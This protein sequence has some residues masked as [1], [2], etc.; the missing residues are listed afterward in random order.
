MDLR[1]FTVYDI[2]KR[3]ARVFNMRVAIQ[4]EERRITFG[5]LYDQTHA[6]IGALASREIQ[7]GDRIAVLTR[8]R[9]EFFP[10]FGAIAALGAIMVPINARLAAEEIRHILA[11]TRPVLFCFEPDFEKMLPE[12]AP[13]C[14][15]VKEL[16]VFGKAGGM[17]TAFD[18]LLN[19]PEGAVAAVTDTDPLVII[20]TAAIQG[21]PRGAMLTHR[22]LVACS[23]HTIG[24]LGLTHDGAYLNILPLFH[25]AGLMAA[26]TMLHAGGKNLLIAKYDPVAAGK[27][28]DREK[29]SF[30]GNFP[31]ILTQ[32]LD[33]QAAG[34][35]SLSA[36]QHV[37]GVELPDTI[38]RFEKLGT[39]RFWLAYGQ[40]ETM[41]LTCFCSNAERPGSAGRP[42]PLV[43]LMIA[44]DADREVDPE[45]PGEILVRG[46]LVFAGY[47]GAE[48]LT[49]NTLRG[50]WHHTGDIGRLDD[51][52]FLW[53]VG[54]KAEKELIK[55]GGENVYPVEV[56]KVVLEH[57]DIQDVS[58]IGI[59][60]PR[61]G[62]GIKA[63]CVLKPGTRLLEKE[64]IDF[65]AGR[66]ARY[67]KP[68]YVE[69]V[70]ALPKTSDGSIDRAKV[71]ALY[72]SG[73]KAQEDH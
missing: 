5:E 45:K 11:D 16:I 28:I 58:V 54:R 15:S 46:P 19:H 60:D 71:K 64:L 34:E 36:L 68:G 6:V 65:V 4:A 35:C 3:N 66:I 29:V 1:S 56:E 30:I 31:P 10:L 41:G 27:L 69:F 26:L 24:A 50:G 22:N 42:G 17:H 61:F 21:K 67:K 52:G 40:T 14:A 53:F 12:L 9:P 62:E 48:E 72:G 38:K 7:R 13:G 51:E 55:P 2:F 18:S 23:I 49:N 70:D 73:A 37:I 44:D 33:A 39:G 8:N 47:W 63:V 43:D 25:I 57:P 20:H 32:L 59:P